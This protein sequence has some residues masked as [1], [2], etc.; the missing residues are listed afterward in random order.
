MSW[1]S[2]VSVLVSRVNTT[3]ADWKGTLSEALAPGQPF[4]DPWVLPSPCSTEAMLSCP[5]E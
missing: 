3:P 2:M 4:F 1:S 5:S